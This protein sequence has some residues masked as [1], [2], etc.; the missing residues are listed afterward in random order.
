VRAQHRAQLAEELR[1]A[2][3]DPYGQG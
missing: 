2:L 1:A 3:R